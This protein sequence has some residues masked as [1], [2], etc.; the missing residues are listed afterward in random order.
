[1][2]L[3]THAWQ[4]KYASKENACKH[5]LIWISLLCW[6]VTSEPMTIC[7]S[8]RNSTWQWTTKRNLCF[9]CLLR[10]GPFSFHNRFSTEHA[11]TVKDQLVSNAAASCDDKGN[12]CVGVYSLPVFE[13]WIWSGQNV[14]RWNIYNWKNNA[15]SLVG[16]NALENKRYRLWCRSCWNV[17][18]ELTTGLL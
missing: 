18:I 14:T 13:S 7:L 12:G 1:M 9:V 5:F 11:C 10:W 2:Q 4:I 15:D 3:L 16:V 6:R 17:L 8:S